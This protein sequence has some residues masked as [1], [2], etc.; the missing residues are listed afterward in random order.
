MT[1]SAGELGIKQMSHCKVPHP[2]W[3]LPP[4]FPFHPK[5]SHHVIHPKGTWLIFLDTNK[6]RTWWSP[7]LVNMYILDHWTGC[8]LGHLFFCGKEKS[9]CQSPKLSDL[10][11]QNFPIELFPNAESY[12]HLSTQRWWT[13]RCDFLQWHDML[14]WTAPLRPNTHEVP[15]PGRRSPFTENITRFACQRQASAQVICSIFP[16][17]FLNN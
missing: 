1:C 6:Q 8:F 11:A 16:V 14:L 9:Q 12:L 3:I 5:M 2:L 4:S 17:Y 13:R 10:N 7:S 15:L